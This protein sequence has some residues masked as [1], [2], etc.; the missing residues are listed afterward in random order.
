MERKVK[1]FLSRVES[2]LAKL[3]STSTMEY[4]HFDQCI[5]ILNGDVR[6]CLKMY[7]CFQILINGR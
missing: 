3:Y 6:A 1:L 2:P 5:M 4:H 7:L